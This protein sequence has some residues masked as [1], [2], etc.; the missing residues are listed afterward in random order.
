LLFYH[1]AIEYCMSGVPNERLLT[2]RVA[3]VSGSIQII[4]SLYQ[5]WLD[6][7][8]AQPRMHAP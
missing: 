7:V 2:A 6:A 3:E 1:Q 4:P 8:G 5:Q